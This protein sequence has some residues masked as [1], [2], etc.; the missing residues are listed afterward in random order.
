M[1]LND[2]RIKIKATH[3]RALMNHTP[4]VETYETKTHLMVCGCGN[5]RDLTESEKFR[6]GLIGRNERRQL[7]IS[8]IPEVNRR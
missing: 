2:R 8:Q 7:P 3:I 6:Y 5:V 1:T 4:H